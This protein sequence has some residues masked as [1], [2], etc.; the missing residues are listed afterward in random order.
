[1][2]NLNFECA[3]C[4]VE[5]VRKL[6]EKGKIGEEVAREALLLFCRWMVEKGFN[7]SPPLL[8]RELYSF[9][10]RA[11]GRDLYAEEKE[12]L[13]RWFLEKEEEFKRSLSRSSDPLDTA[14]RW[15]IVGNVIDLGPA[16]EYDWKEKFS[17]AE[18]EVV[19]REK[20]FAELKSRLLKSRRV[21]FLCD[22]CGEVG[23][24][25]L[26]AEVLK[27]RGKEVVF[28]VRSAPTINDCTMKEAEMI[29]LT[30]VGTVLPS[31][32]T[33]S[34]IYEEMTDELK[35]EVERAEV[36]I[37]KGQ[38]NLEGLL[39][40]NMNKMYHLLVVKCSVI[41]EVVGAPKGTLVCVRNDEV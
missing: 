26:V 31:N 25:K 9:M 39:G 14:L 16:K 28:A 35:R 38:G 4:A 23:F 21:L 18:S 6:K 10:N 22:N 8:G 7:S 11:M 24:D 41:S 33:P 13:Q 27:S 1:M 12:A 19:H 36:I 32:D 30:E 40:L 2:I 3:R 20:T 29:G 15:A 5:A 37:A 17:S 34:F